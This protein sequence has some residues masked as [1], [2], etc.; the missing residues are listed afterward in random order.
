MPLRLD[1]ASQFG[2]AFVAAVL[3]L[4][5]IVFSAS[6]LFEKKRLLY[7]WGEGHTLLS[8]SLAEH[9]A[10]SMDAVELLLDDVQHDLGDKSWWNW[11]NS[12]AGHEYLH[13]R[14]KVKL[15]QLRH[16]LIFD[17]YGDQRHTSFSPTFKPINVKDRPYW[18]QFIAGAES[19]SY[20][21]F[22]GR[23]TGKMVYAFI[24]RLENAEGNFAGILFA[25]MEPD[26]FE[27]YCQ[28][29]FRYQSLVG[30]LVNQAGE[31]I[32]NC[33][34]SG[35]AEVAV[36]KIQ[37]LIADEAIAGMKDIPLETFTQG[38]EYQLAIVPVV[39]Y[40][41]LR[42]VVAIQTEEV[43]AG[44]KKQVMRFASLLFFAIVLLS[45]SGFIIW[46]QFVRLGEMS[47]KLRA[48]NQ[49]LEEQ[50]RDRTSELLIAKE[51][52]EAAS[53]AKS[54]FLAN[55]SH[56]LRT[57]MSAIIGM[58]NLA[59]RNANNPKVT[60]QIGKIGIAS[61]HLLHVIND[62]LDIS[63][64]EAERLTVAHS[65]FRL[66][67]TIENL[68]SL[69][70]Q[71]ASEKGI[72]LYVDLPPDLFSLGVMGDPMRLGQILI[73]LTGN[74]VK[75]T[76]QGSVTLRSK[77]VEESPSDLLLRWEIAD[78]GIG[79]SVDDQK[80]LFTAF[81]QAD[82]SM[83]RKYGGTG[84]G[85][86]ISKRLAGMM[87][88]EIGLE[89][90]PGKGSTFWFTVRLEKAR[91]ND[92]PPTP[93]FSGKSA[94]ERLLDEYA[95]TRILLAED[96]PITQE[97]SRVLLEDAGLAVDLAEDGLQALTLAKQNTY[98]LILMDMQMPHM[99]GVEATMS[100][101]ALPGYAL[102][103]ILAMTANAFDEDRQV[104]I[105]AGMDDHI[106]KPVNPDK[107]YETLLSWL[108]KR[109]N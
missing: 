36:K 57:P 49:E 55:M 39:G 16:L 3:A 47:A 78:T 101:R 76:E 105:D 20:G 109:G 35:D 6:D 19:A 96:E 11:P 34:R 89:S 7:E 104:C 27:D 67:E 85:L 46:R 75:F 29:L 81:E 74:A 23:N 44:W 93:T 52:S 30:A 12:E 18:A 13:S 90:E 25:A 9:V 40:G 8:R 60:D 69:I 5:V 91:S 65:R 38:K 70:S 94:E 87:G 80:K 73:N 62:I 72:K 64:I 2:F 82:G 71:K 50:V 97:I 103:P 79:I 68:L 53:R 37:S 17:A 84:L 99:N 107:L 41:N 43:L 83:T 98:A 32:A 21:P 106:A 1:R 63:K 58:A 56:E 22:V 28:S 14:L 15:P 100:I 31:I 45:L 92:A 54:A 102:T 33:R 24:R 77:I 51:K 10:R 108:E 95:G 4:V 86:A 26:Y 42:V 48:Q 88:G 59:L 66:G 61:K